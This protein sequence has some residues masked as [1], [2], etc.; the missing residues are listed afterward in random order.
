MGCQGS[1]TPHKGAGYA[2][3]L[4]YVWQARIGT[5]TCKHVYYTHAVHKVGKATD[6]S[7]RDL[8]KHWT[9]SVEL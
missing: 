7:E 2:Y 9:V 5:A 6:L 4:Y 1:H 3:S 8:Q